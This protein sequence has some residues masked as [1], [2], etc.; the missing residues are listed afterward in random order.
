MINEFKLP[1]LKCLRCGH[2]W[3]PRIE[4]MPKVCPTCK[5]PYWNTER[6]NKRR[7]DK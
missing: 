1:K 7:E 5:N 4:T 2:E 3:C 6:K